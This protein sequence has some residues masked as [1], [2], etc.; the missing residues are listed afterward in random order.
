[1]R[2]LSLSQLFSSAGLLLSETELTAYVREHKQSFWLALAIL[3]NPAL[4]RTKPMPQGPLTNYL[5]LLQSLVANRDI[6]DQSVLRT[7]TSF[8]F[9]LGVMLFDVML[10]PTAARAGCDQRR[11]NVA[12]QACLPRLG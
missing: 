2:S 8:Y 7:A 10:L 3:P 6:H 12:E 4:S 5:E 1:M 9:Y 11:D